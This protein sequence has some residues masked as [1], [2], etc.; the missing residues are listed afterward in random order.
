M[1]M[2][3]RSLTQLTMCYLKRNARQLSALKFKNGDVARK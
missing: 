1:K 2:R 3:H